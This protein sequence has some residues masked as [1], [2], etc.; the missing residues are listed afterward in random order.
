LDN[1]TVLETAVLDRPRDVE[2]WASPSNLGGGAVALAGWEDDPNLTDWRRHR[3]MATTL[4][5]V[6]AALPAVQFIHMDVEGSELAILAGAEQLLARSPHVRIIAEWG[7]HHAPSYFD[8]ETGLEF[9]IA[10]GF[11]FW[12]ICPDSTLLPQNK[13]Q[14]LACEFGDVLIARDD[15]AG[16]FFPGRPNPKEH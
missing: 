16:S 10:G 5:T 12:Q 14:M 13:D 1:V 7:A 15:P 9:L 11:R 6:T 2:L 8:I 4:D 3:T